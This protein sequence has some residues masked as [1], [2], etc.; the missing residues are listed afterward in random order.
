MAYAAVLHGMD[1]HYDWKNETVF[2][3]L[4]GEMVWWDEALSNEL[5]STTIV[6]SILAA[7]CLYLYPYPE[8]LT[9]EL[10]M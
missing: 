10:F 3:G 7:I 1:M 5:N 4:A 9:Y 6:L 2:D 8:A